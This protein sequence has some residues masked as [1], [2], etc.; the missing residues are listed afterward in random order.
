MSNLLLPNWL[1]KHLFVYRPDTIAAE[2]LH[3]LRKRLAKF[4]V[5]KPEISIVIPAY[6]EEANLLHTLSS[7]ADQQ[8]S[9]PTELLVVNNNSADRTQELLDQ[10]GVRSIIERRPGVAFARQAGLEA[11]RGVYMANA[12]ADCLYPAGWVEAIT[13]PLHDPAI[14]CTYG[15]YAFLPSQNSSRLAL[16][17]YEKIAQLVNSVRNRDKTFMNVYGFNFAFRRADALAVGGFALDSGREGSVAELVAAGIKPPPSGKC[18]DGWMSLSLQQEGKGRTF[19]VTDPAAR[20]WTSDR[21]LL[22]DGSLGKAFITR[23]WQ[24]VRGLA[25]PFSASGSTSS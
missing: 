15:L 14:A 10:C 6:N 19:R 5:D 20:V 4:N 22:A 7:L 18:E 21:R 25:S 12:D 11:A 1:S 17:G 9:R 16:M 3:D 23:V 24:A 8:L 2:Q 13:K